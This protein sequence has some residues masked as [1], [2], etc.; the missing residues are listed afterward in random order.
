MAGAVAAG[1]FFYKGYV[2]KRESGHAPASA[3]RITPV[4]GPSAVGAEFTLRF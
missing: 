1:Y 4:I 3:A 2:Q